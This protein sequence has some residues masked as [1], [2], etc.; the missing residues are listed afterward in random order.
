MPRPLTRADQEERVVRL[1]AQ[2]EIGRALRV[3][4][5]AA[6]EGIRHAD[7]ATEL[8]IDETTF[9]ALING[10]RVW[11]AGPEDLKVRVSQA[12]DRLG[13]RATGVPTDAPALSAG[14][15]S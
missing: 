11:V 9:S 2:Q 3:H 6:T 10:R 15:A 14:G 13:V 12:L 5:A 8:G 4:L 1:R 7:I